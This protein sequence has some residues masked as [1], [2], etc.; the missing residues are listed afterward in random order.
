MVDFLEKVVPGLLTAVLAAYLTTRWSLRRFYAEKWW[1]RKERAYSEIIDCLY[2]LI[3]YCEICIE[4]IEDPDSRYAKE[5]VEPFRKQYHDAYWKIKHAA[6]IGSFVICKSAVDA[7]NEFLNRPK[8]DWR[9]RDSHELF[10]HEY[11]HAKKTLDKLRV[12]AV[13][14][15][16]VTK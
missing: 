6:T 2:H 7:L 14:D 8:L 13:T 12:I 11:E 5:I 16:K 1:D 4:E 15:L 3:R 9:N 10:S